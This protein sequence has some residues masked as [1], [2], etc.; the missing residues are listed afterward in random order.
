MK[1]KLRTNLVAFLC[2]LFIGS[3]LHAQDIHWSQF[4]NSPL[5]LSP[6][7]TGVHRGDIRFSGNYRNQWRNVPVN[8]MTFSAGVDKK[9]FNKKD[10]N[11]F[12]A[13]GLLFDYDRA[14]DSKLS[15]TKIGLNGSYT[16]GLDLKNFLTFGAQIAFNQRAFKTEDLRFDN[17]WG[18]DLFDPTRGT[19]ENFKNTTKVFGDFSAGVNYHFQAQTPYGI[20]EKKSD[21]NRLD[22]GVAYFHI[23][24]PKISFYEQ[25]DKNLAGRW[26]VYGNAVLALADKLDL[27][28]L[29]LGQFQGPHQEIVLGA[30]G[31]IHLKQD[32]YGNR[33]QEVALQIGLSYR[34]DDAWIPNLELHYGPWLFGVSYDITTSDWINANNRRGGPEFSVIHIITKPKAPNYKACQLF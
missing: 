3:A 9:F 25:D 20:R 15:W 8:Y 5:N 32:A 26:T 23:N 33:D 21:R 6:G 1:T 18:G 22:L 7:L 4:N 34:L 13:G 19:G 30:G 2:L 11:G 12:F 27:A 17:Q 24:Q 10:E 16:R 31:R 14:G 29:A 28:L